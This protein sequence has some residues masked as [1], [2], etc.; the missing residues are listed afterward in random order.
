MGEIRMKNNV[1]KL[2]LFLL[3]LLLVILVACGQSDSSE[4]SEAETSGEA[5]E[6]TSSSDSVDSIELSISHFTTTEHGY[7]KTVFVPF[8][9]E[10]EERTEGRITATIY[11]GAALGDPP[12]QY[13]LVT[14]GI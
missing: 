10:L 9:E 8:A 13:E 5:T 4:S 1:K 12:S 14:E 11:P 6:A 2:S 7:H 3:M